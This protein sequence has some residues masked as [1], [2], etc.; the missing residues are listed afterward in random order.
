MMYLLNVQDALEI[1]QSEQ[2]NSALFR[3]N[4]VTASEQACKCSE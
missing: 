1:H 2:M 3:C 4:D